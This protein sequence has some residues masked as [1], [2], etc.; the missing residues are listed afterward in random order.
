MSAG[1]VNRTTL[2]SF[3]Q[4]PGDTYDDAKTE[5]A[6]NTL[7]DQSDENWNYVAG[8]V[9]GGVLQPYPAF[10]SRQAVI[11]GNFDVWQRGTSFATTS[12]GQYTADRWWSYRGASASVGHNQVAITQLIGSRYCMRVDRSAGND[13]FILGTSFGTDVLKKFLGKTIAASVYL[14]KGSALTSNIT[15]TLQTITAEESI[16][17]AVDVATATVPVSSLDTLNFTR[18]TVSLTIP[19]NSTALGLEFFVLASQ[20]G[21]GNVYYDVAQVQINEGAIALPFQPRSFAEELAL[22]QRYCYSITDP[23]NGASN[24]GMGTAAA[25]TIVV[26]PVFLPVTMRI[27]PT[28]VAS[29]A[30]WA[31]FDG[32]AGGITLTAIG[33]Q[34]EQSSN[35]IPT[36]RATVASGLTQFRP[37]LLGANGA[38][39]LLIFDAEL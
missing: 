7:A 23:N 9:A 30:D 4:N 15:L 25:T 12:N 1:L 8:L 21:G 2:Q 3:Y 19:A 34:P 17:T 33:L 36:I 27:A 6:V 22:C 29:A 14:R 37:Y 10:M 18:F 31:L 38:M 35:T 11:N 5:G 39:K 16:G 13:Q 24:V 20:A 32:N 28:L 26:V